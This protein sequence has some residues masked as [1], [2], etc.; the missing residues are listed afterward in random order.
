MG[1][2]GGA[3]RNWK[4][5]LAEEAGAGG[6]WDLEGHVVLALTCQSDLPGGFK[7]T[8]VWAP[9][10]RSSDCGWSGTPPA[11]GH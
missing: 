11:L 5:S 6:T 8:A 9:P 2:A 7:K 1:G 4:G 3:G 10:Q